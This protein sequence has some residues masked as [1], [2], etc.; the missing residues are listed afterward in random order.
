M[1]WTTTGGGSTTE[2]PRRRRRLRGG[3]RGTTTAM[4]STAGRGSAAAAAVAVVSTTTGTGSPHLR[5]GT[6]GTGRCTGP[7]ASQASGGSSPRGSAR[8]ATGLGGTVAAARRGGGRAAG[9]GI[10]K[11]WT[12]T[13]RRPGGPGRRRRRRHC[14]CPVSLAGGLMVRGWRSPGSRA[15]ASARWRKG[16]LRQIPRPRPALLRWITG[17]RSSFLGMPR[18]KDRSAVR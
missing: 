6:A 9:G 15:L 12:G 7:R 2:D 17:S 1:T 10:R 16:R 11:V 8:S 4:G 13:G 5:E 3:G 18:R 14:G